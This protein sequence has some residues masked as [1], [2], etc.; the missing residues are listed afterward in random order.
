ML[1]SIRKLWPLAGLLVSA[2]LCAQPD[3]ALDDAPETEPARR[4]AVEVLLFRYGSGVSPGTEIFVP[5]E[6]PVSDVPV[7]GDG[8]GLAVEGRGQATD[9]DEPQAFGDLTPLPDAADQPPVPETEAELLSELPTS[10]SIELT[11]LSADELTMTDEYATLQRL[12]AYEPV[13]WSGWTQIVLEDTRTAAVDLR[14][15]GRIPLAYDGELKLYLSRFLHLVVD[16]E[17]TEAAQQTQMIPDVDPLQD[18]GAR[19]TEPAPPRKVSHRI[20]EDRIVNN[21]DL[22]YFD[23]PK[24]GLLA[25]LTLVEDD[26]GEGDEES[27]LLPSAT[28]VSPPR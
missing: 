22:R 1:R 7:F 3:R 8:R 4:Y 10:T 5:D 21:G 15:L 17:L 16:L 13:L 27:V 9:G 19:R 20:E 14:R 6:E 23:H 11:V 18:R 28:A 12:D 25:K 24:F 2:P 26:A